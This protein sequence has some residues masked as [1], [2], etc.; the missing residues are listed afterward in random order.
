[1]KKI[2]A[3]LIIFIFLFPLL[4]EAHSPDE[5][6]IKIVK[7]KNGIYLMDR[8]IIPMV[9]QVVIGGV[10]VMADASDDITGVEFMVPPKVGCRLVVIY[11]DTSPPY[12][13]YWN[14]SFDGLKDKGF[15]ALK[16]SG[17]TGKAYVAENNI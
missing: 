8:R 11:N 12:S 9:G 10:T 7:P 14:F 16:A 3:G 6:Y 2:A 5:T 13:F 17:Y 15:V 4:G 1:M